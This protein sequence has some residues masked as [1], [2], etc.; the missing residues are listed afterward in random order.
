MVYESGIICVRHKIFDAFSGLRY[1]IGDILWSAF[2]FFFFFDWLQ[3]TLVCGTY[4]AISPT[5]TK[6]THKFSEIE[7]TQR[8]GPVYPKVVSL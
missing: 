8:F 1:F 5:I 7:V 4:F 3:I 6:Q 2:F